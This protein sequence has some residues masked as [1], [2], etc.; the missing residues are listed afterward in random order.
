MQIVYRDFHCLWHAP[1][2]KMTPVV[3]GRGTVTQANV[4]ADGSEAR[5]LPVA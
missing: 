3:T 4:E 1:E 2:I 5:K